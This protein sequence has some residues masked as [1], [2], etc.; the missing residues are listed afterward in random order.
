MVEILLS[1]Y[2]GEK[3]LDEQL[4]SLET[5]TFSDW[6]LTVRDDGSSDGAKDILK[7]WKSRL[8]EKMRIVEAEN[9]GVTR[10]FEKLLEMTDAEYVM[11][12]DQDDVWLP[13]KIE[14]TMEKMREEELRS[15]GKAVMIFTSIELVD[16]KLEP[17]GK[18]FFQQNKFDFPFALR[19]ENL[20]VNNCVAGCTTMLNRKARELVLPF[21]KNA[22]IH[23]WW[24]SLRVAKDGIIS[25]LETPTMLYRQHGDNVCGAEPAKVRHYIS[26][27]I[28]PWEM[29]REF[30]RVEPFLRDAGF[31]G[32]ARWFYYKIRHL[33]RRKIVK[34]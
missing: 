25:V 8:G 12:C 30:K 1:T 11:L 23:D 15:P 2:N 33:L 32:E 21:S 3:W 31:E 19:F 13:R 22:L 28:K 6:K 29:H 27:I 16:S 5:Q 14:W 26:L 10:S 17:M 20:C 7:A 18:T 24:M 4:Q 34:R 9:V